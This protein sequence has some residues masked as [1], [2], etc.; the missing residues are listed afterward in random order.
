MR[1]A[2]GELVQWVTLPEKFRCA[3]LDDFKASTAEAARDA[4]QSE[5][6]SLLIQGK[7]G[8]GK[9]HLAAAVLYELAKDVEKDHDW[10]PFPRKGFMWTT[11]PSLLMRF[12]SCYAPN[13]KET[14]LGI[15][16]ELE[17]TPHLVLDD[18]GAEKVTDWS[19]SA[20]YVVVN[21]RDERMNRPIIV[22]TNLSLD[23]IN[24]MEP[25]IA[26]RLGG[27][28]RIKLAGKD[29]RVG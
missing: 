23:E 9:T 17:E 5:A 20:L 27:Y 1:Q 6:W 12:R 19:L 16:R 21:G 24:A 18:V 13:A 11:V 8:S 26:S 10:F 25:R 28:R 22:T 4:I 14:E 29:R 2:N 3:R 15:V 7:N